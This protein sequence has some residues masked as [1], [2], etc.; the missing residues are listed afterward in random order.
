MEENS[1]ELHRR[2]RGVIETNSKIKIKN[3]DDY[4]NFYSPEKIDQIT[5]EIE[6]DYTKAYDLTPKGNLV[7]IIT[8]GSAVLGFGNIGP[9]AAL[10]VMEGKA[11]LF[12]TLAGVDAVPLCFNTQDPDRLIEL[13]SHITPI[14]GGINLE[15]IASPHCF[16]IEKK[17]IETLNIPVFHDDQHGTAVVVLAG[18]INALKIVDKKI[19]NIKIVV[20]GAGAG[21][22]SVSELL[23]QY[24]VK[25]LILCD[26]QGA[27]YKGRNLGMNPYKEIFAHKT[28]PDNEKGCLAS[29]IRGAD[30]FIGLS[31]GNILNSEMI[32]SMANKPVIFALANPIPEIMPEIAYKSGAFIVAT[33]RSDFKNQINNSLAFPGIFRGALDVRAK[34]INNDMKINAAFAIAGLLK[35][36]EL[37]PEYIIP[38]ALD[39]RVPPTVAKS[40]AESAI[41][42]NVAQVNINPDLIFEKT[43]NYLYII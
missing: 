11:A 5:K 20:N 18:F 8:D 1:L 22:L 24:G 30:F 16:E 2:A 10:P 7:A 17:L 19:E 14:F 35:D 34:K 15:D 27:I 29:V 41:K 9:E 32:K 26:R 43:K 12:K 37:S 33:G 42:T 40:V 23:L 31:A 38:H 36:S 21:A 6:L 4:E 39:F 13:I 25:N 3:S 28:N